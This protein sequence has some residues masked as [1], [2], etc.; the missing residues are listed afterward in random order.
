VHHSNKYDDAPMPYMQRLTWEGVALHAGNLPGYPASHGCI[1]LP[2][3]FAR[4]LYAVT[5]R[6]ATVVITDEAVEPEVAPTPLDFDFDIATDQARSV[7]WAPR[8]SPRG[9]ISLVVSGR[10]RKL[11]V[12]RNG[13]RIGETTITARQPIVATT[14]YMLQ[15]ID[16]AGLHWAEL[17]LPGVTAGQHP[18][19]DDQ[20]ARAA[21]PAAFRLQLLSI[22]EPG[23]TLLV[24]RDTLSTTGTGRRLKVLDAALAD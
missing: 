11:I 21:I 23:A 17:P 19:T 20:G 9:P 6:G 3:D 7:Y 24:T 22:L 5:S 14:A 2:P 18:L 1:R 15:S 12:L 8:R 10:D 4:A 13:I 16:A